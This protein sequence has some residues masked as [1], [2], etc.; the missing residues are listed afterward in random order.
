MSTMIKNFA[1]PPLA[2]V[3]GGQFL[4]PPLEE[5]GEVWGRG[6]YHS[7]QSLQKNHSSGNRQQITY[8][9]FQKTATITTENFSKVEIYNT[10][11]QLIETKTVNTFRHLFLQRRY[12]LLQSLRRQQ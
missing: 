10:I 9:S 11:G 4:F 2:G 6:R 8:N 12:L 3:G 5:L 1:Y 7:F